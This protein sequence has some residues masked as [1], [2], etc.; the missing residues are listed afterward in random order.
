MTT[1][2]PTSSTVMKYSPQK[3]RLIADALRGLSVDEAMA[4]LQLMNKGQTKKFYELIKT[5]TNN[6]NATPEEFKDLKISKLVCEEAQK[7]YRVMPRARGSAFR[8][9][10]RFSRIKLWLTNDLTVDNPKK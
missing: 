1:N 5:G 6:L 10:R 8:I 7:Y 2:K 9:R 3:A 4:Q